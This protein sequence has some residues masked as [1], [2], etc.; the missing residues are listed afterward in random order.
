MNET[1]GEA[2]NWR[3]SETSRLHRIS[4]VTALYIV[5]ERQRYYCARM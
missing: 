4:I 5:F 1:L 3:F 2:N